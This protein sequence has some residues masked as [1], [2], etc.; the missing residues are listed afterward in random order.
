MKIMTKKGF[1]MVMATV[2]AA[3]LLVIALAIINMSC[4][5]ITQTKVSNDADKAYYAAV[6]GA[7]KMYGLLKS[8]EGQVII[9][10]QVLSTTDIATRGTGG[11]TVG[12][13]QAR[14]DVVVVDNILGIV[15][16]GS[17]NG[18]TATVTVQYGYTM[19]FNNGYPIGCIGPMSLKGA[20]IKI[21]WFTFTSY[22]RAE[23]PIA[24]GSTIST[25]GNLVQINGDTLQNQGFVQ[26]NFWWAYNSTT[27]ACDIQKTYGDTNG[28]SVYVEDAN[29][30]GSLTIADAGDDLAKQ[31]AFVVDDINSDGVVNDKDAFVSYYTVEL[32]HQGL[33]IGQ[34]QSGY[35]N[36]SQSFNP[37]SVPA[38]TPIIF[39]NGDVNIAFND[40]AWWA[41]D[42]NHTIVATGNINIVQ[43]TNSAGQTLAL[44]S[45]GNV[46]TGGLNFFG[47]INGNL[48]VYANGNFNAYYGGKS[49]GTIFANGVVN[50]DTL[51]PI[52][53]LLNRDLN[54]GTTNWT[55]PANWPLGLPRNFDTTGEGFKML[56]E[57]VEDE[58]FVPI[59]Q[60]D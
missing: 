42:A 6:T 47:G 53:G 59:W 46:N 43:P 55:N 52:P 5:E 41:Q 40:M 30:D 21:L 34:G 13:F 29:H 10:P 35:Y 8:K 37:G 19:P 2:F 38:G 44:I 58:G 18:R 48:V 20:R 17:A 28:N 54:K 24:S 51:L 23:G 45:Y 36:G 12:T 7:E 39:V 25:N 31:E 14:A 49:N 4:G 26:P 60:R 57:Q 3:A 16:R 1:V 11:T 32:N 22:V 33:N 50:I 27:G 9:W 15:S 56:K